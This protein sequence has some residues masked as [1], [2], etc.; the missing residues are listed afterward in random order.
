MKNLLIFALVIPLLV[1]GITNSGSAQALATHAEAAP[2][3]LQ[4][5]KTIVDPAGIWQGTVS[6]DL[7]GNLTTVLTDLRI[8]GSIWRVEFDWIIDAG[9]QSFTAH[10]KGILNTKTGRVVMNGVVTEGWLLGAQVHEEGQ[11]VDPDTLR[12]QGTIRVMPATA[13]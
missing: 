6:G 4:F 8:S 10:L 12:F 11:L 5:D 9:P 13:D 3:Y 2:V 1:A 7:N